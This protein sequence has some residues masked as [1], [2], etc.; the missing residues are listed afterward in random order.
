MSSDWVTLSN[1]P[2]VISFNDGTPVSILVDNKT[3]TNTDG[4][5]ITQVKVSVITWNGTAGTANT[6]VSALQKQ[7]MTSTDFNT[8]ML[9]WFNG[10][11]TTMPIMSGVLYNNGGTLAIS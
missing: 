11:P 6:L 1:E 9:N 4:V 10:L 7:T 8:Y 3:T 5:P 2:I